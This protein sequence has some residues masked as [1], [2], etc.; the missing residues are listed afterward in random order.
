MTV[1]ELYYRFSLLIN[2]ND[3]NEGVKIP[4]ASF[5]LL[6][7]S[8]MLRWLG[9]ELKKDSDNIDINM[10]E[11][12]WVPNK[13]LQVSRIEEE[14]IEHLAP[15]D[16][17]QI[18]GTFSIASTKECTGIKIFN[19]EKKPGNIIPI[20][21][22]RAEG[23]SLEYEEAPFVVGGDK[24]IIYKGKD[25]NIDRSFINYY[26]IP[27]YIDIEGYTHFDGTQSTNVDPE[28]DD[29]NCVQVLEKLAVEISRQ[30]TDSEKFQFDK[31]RTLTN[32][33]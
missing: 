33:N 2:K 10:I 8:E 14:F 29:Y 28:L 3:T 13:P 4:E 21:E 16:F 31:D 18:Y 20:L 9:E 15:S 12:L 22:D 23:P 5:V 24:V 30:T 6:F 7:N 26:R 27:K 19:Y 11:L 1:Q 32:P 25:Y 17:F